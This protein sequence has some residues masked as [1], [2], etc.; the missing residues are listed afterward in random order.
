MELESARSD[1]PGQV[2]AKY[3]G[4]LSETQDY[5]SPDIL[6]IEVNHYS[7]KN[8]DDLDQEIAYSM[9]F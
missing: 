3:A 2:I 4:V 8:K 1:K 6:S 9:E 7:E 5:N